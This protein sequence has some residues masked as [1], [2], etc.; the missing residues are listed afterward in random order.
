[1]NNLK[2]YSLTVHEIAILTDLLDDKPAHIR[3][4]NYLRRGGFEI[5]A[6]VVTDQD[7]DACW[8]LSANRRSARKWSV[9]MSEVCF[10]RPMIYH[11][12]LWRNGLGP[13][14]ELRSHKLKS[15][16]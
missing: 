5:Y 1:M 6:G 13:H 16:S 7:G 3:L 4:R 8:H 9:E 10:A 11:V 15:S 14:E 12:K 2:L